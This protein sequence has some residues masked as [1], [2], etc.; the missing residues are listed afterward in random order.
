MISWWRSTGVTAVCCWMEIKTFSM[1]R[2]LYGGS[3]ICSTVQSSSAEV[4]CTAV[5]FL[6]G[7]CAGLAFVCTSFHLHTKSG[8]RV[9]RLCIHV[10][11][12]LQFSIVRLLVPEDSIIAV[13]TV[14]TA[15]RGCF[16]SI[17]DVYI[18]WSL[19]DLV[20]ERGTCWKFIENTQYTVVKNEECVTRIVK[21]LALP[22]TSM[23]LSA[24]QRTMIILSCFMITS[25]NI[26]LTGSVYSSL[27]V[28][29]MLVTLPSGTFLF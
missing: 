8:L 29:C 26:F 24:A 6:G 28:V 1:R 27:Y 10:S 16:S 12:K 11:Q 5:Q 2:F 9:R 25:K 7:Q 4:N 19:V 17:F 20:A 18:R 13:N 23:T 3:V 22:E 14:W 15:Y 21:K